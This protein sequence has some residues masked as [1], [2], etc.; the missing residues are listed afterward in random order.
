MES[1]GYKHNL[2]NK[3]IIHLIKNTNYIFYTGNDTLTLST[4]LWNQF[5]PIFYIIFYNYNNLFF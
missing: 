5:T 1:N 3:N 4:N 2:N